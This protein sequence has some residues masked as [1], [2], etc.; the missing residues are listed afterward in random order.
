MSPK[1]GCDILR[2]EQILA[3]TLDVVADRSLEATR[4]RDIAAAAGLS[5]PGPGYSVAR[6]PAGFLGFSPP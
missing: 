6:G 2:R 4:V 3:A 1:A 5:P